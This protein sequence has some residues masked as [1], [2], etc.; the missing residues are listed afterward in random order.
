MLGVNVFAADTDGEARR[1]FTSVQQAFVRLRRGEPSPLPPPVDDVGPLLS[2]TEQALVRRTLSCS[3]IG[4]AETVRLGLE[5]FVAKT[6]PDELIVVSQVFDH[7]A[8]LRSYELA[9]RVRDEMK[10]QFTEMR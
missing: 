7:A 5:D 8:R 1:L 4:T 6:S 2:R 10:G 9:A 3:F